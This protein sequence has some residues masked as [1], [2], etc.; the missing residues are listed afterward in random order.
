MIKQAYRVTFRA[1]YST[2]GVMHRIASTVIALAASPTS[3]VPI[4]RDKLTGPIVDY[5]LTADS[6]TIRLVKSVRR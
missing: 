2:G 1:T 6:V 4:A 5:G 3:V